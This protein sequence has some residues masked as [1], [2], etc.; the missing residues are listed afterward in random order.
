MRAQL[1]WQSGILVRVWVSGHA[2]AQEL[3]V[4]VS[5]LLRSCA[6][7]VEDLQAGAYPLEWDLALPEEGAFAWRLDDW[8]AELTGRLQGISLV[9]AC[10]LRRLAE[11]YPDLELFVDT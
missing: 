5:C 6:L 10:G 3:C 8:G 7:A 4:A 2:A 11:D 1:T 9:L